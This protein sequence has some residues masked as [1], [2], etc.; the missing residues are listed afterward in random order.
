M[1]RSVGLK[2]VSLKASISIAYVFLAFV[3]TATAQVIVTDGDTI[4]LDGITY[5]LNGIDA[6]EFGQDCAGLSGTWPC[7]NVALAALARLV[8]G[9]NVRC[10]PISEDG[11][12]RTIAT[13]YVGA[14]DVGAE[15][16]Q[17]GLAW[18]F[19]RYSDAYVLAEAKARSEQKGIWQTEN[20]PAWDYR[21]EKWKVAEQQAPDGCP[22]KGN[23]SKNGHIYHP[24]WS[25]WYSRTK[26]SI[27]RGERWFCSEAE[28]VEAGWRAPRWR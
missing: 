27:D 5:R 16:I 2:D 9:Q 14:I 23:I 24:P 28:A 3:S 6:P 12:G 19:V 21:A 8:E 7:G 4:E 10:Q 18:A 11:Y 25:P 17:E 1:L 22:I 20:V 26:V 15:L 13:C